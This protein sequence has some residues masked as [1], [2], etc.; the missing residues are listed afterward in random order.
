[1]TAVTSEFCEALIEQY[2][3]APEAK[4]NNLLTVDGFTAFLLSTECDI[5]DP[6]HTDVFQ[7]AFAK[8]NTKIVNFSYIPEILKRGKFLG[9]ETTVQPLFHLFLPKNLPG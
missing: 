7:V 4:E 3:P 5:F 9:H 6:S 2:E 8:A 1:M